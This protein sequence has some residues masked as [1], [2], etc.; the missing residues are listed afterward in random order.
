MVYLAGAQDPNEKITGLMTR[1][2][3]KGIST[4]FE[5]CQLFDF[6]GSMIQG[7][8]GFFRGFGAR[9]VPLLHIRKNELPLL[10]R[11]ITRLR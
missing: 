9:P 11:W 1:L 10:V 6:E 5:R 7:V 8:E 4:G 2:V 3:W